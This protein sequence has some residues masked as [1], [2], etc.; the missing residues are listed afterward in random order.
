M[1]VGVQVMADVVVDDVNRMRNV[2]QNVPK[3][4]KFSCLAV[5]FGYDDQVV[6]DAG[7]VAPVGLYEGLDG[8]AALSKSRQIK[9]CDARR[10]LAFCPPK[11]LAV[12]NHNMTV[13]ASPFAFSTTQEAMRPVG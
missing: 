5:P 3:H 4:G 12:L 2:T 13:S 11:Y 8:R 1:L 10:H 7:I 6:G 9:D